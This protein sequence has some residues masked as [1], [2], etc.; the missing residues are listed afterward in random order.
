MN[1]KPTIKGLFVNSHIAAVEKELGK[2][3]VA[4]L[5]KRFGKPLNFKNN[6][7]VRV[8]DEIRII[9][10]ALDL[11]SKKPVPPAKRAYEAGRLH[12]ISF[13]NTSFAKMAFPMFRNNFKTMMLRSGFFGEHIFKGVKFTTKELGA[14][15]VEVVME[16]NDYPI[17]HFRGLF[18]A[19]MDA[20]GLTGVV[21]AEETGEDAFTF[22]ME[23]Q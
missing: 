11:L 1:T 18:Q 17:D 19:W 20:S 10:Y 6:Q 16:N 13:S 2:Q 7:E 5:E 3:G 23:W 12:F 22:I 9:E 21:S 4:E 15:K 8:L 14:K